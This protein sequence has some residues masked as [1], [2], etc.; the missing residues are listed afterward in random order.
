MIIV[1]TG[2][3]LG[4]M[5][6]RSRPALGAGAGHDSSGGGGLR[7]D[8]FDAL[9]EEDPR[10]GLRILFDLGRIL[11]QRLR[12]AQSPRVSPVPDAARALRPPVTPGE[13]EL[14]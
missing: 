13:L 7:L 1:G 5:N 2:S 14:S 4:E 12:R 10:L 9:A 8:D 3:V 6:S 11:A